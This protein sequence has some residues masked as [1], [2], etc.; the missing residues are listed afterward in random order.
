MRKLSFLL[1]GLV[2]L[3]GTA[4][5]SDRVIDGLDLGDTQRIAFTAQF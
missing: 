4:P 3:A 5:P 1:I 2:L